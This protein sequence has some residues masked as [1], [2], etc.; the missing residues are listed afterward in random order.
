MPPSMPTTDRRD[1]RGWARR[2]LTVLLT[3]VV[4]V[5]GVGLLFER[6]VG[7]LPDPEGCHASVAGRVVDLDTEQGENAAVIAA[8]GVRRGLPARAVSIALATAFQE[9]K[10]HNLDHGDR[11][12]LGL[13]QQRP[14]M[15]WGTAAQI[16]DPYYAANRFYDELQKV[17]DYQ[18]MRITVA[19][20][21]VQRSGFPDA[22]A[23]HAAD[24]RALSS[25]LTGFS[26][27][28]FSCVVHNPSS[29]DQVSRQGVGAGGLTAR[30]EAVRTDVQKAFGP[31]PTGHYKADHGV[32]FDIF[33]EPTANATIRGWAIAHYLVAQAN[34]LDIAQVSFGNRRWGI[35]SA[36]EKGWQT[37]PKD[38]AHQIHV[39]VVSG[40]S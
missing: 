34:R 27:A 33:L 19:A 20:Q 7:P 18:T 12:S 37:V 16:Q 39:A 11:D 22:Y 13:F 14:S 40:T 8:V 5:G 21:R 3:I 32:G 38:H 9:S 1:E 15:G 29:F 36:S 25:A 24:A 26:P 10:L 2:S 28:K 17:N 23:G 4:V 31:L 35:G 30:A 6:G